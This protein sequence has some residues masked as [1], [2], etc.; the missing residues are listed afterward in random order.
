[1]ERIKG[2][3][4]VWEQLMR[5]HRAPTHQSERETQRS[6]SATQNVLFKLKVF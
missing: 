1:M 3:R 6:P 2:R 5:L 4:Q